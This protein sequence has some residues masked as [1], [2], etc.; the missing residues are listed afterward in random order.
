MKLYIKVLGP[1]ERVEI[2]YNG[3]KDWQVVK[4]KNNKEQYK[5]L[6]DS[7]EEAIAYYNKM[8]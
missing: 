5:Y 6:V 4:Y 3:N 2:Q 7:E 8:N 1:D